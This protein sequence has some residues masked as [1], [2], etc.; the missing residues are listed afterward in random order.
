MVY[1][2]RESRDAAQHGGG[3]GGGGRRAS[4]LEVRKLDAMLGYCEL[5]HLPSPDA[6]RLLR[7]H[8]ARALR[9]LRQLPGSGRGPG[10]RT[11][12]CQKAMSCVYRTGPSA[13][14]PRISSMSC[15]AGRDPTA[16]AASATTAFR[17][18]GRARTW[19]R[20]NGARCSASWWRGGL[21][22]VDMEG[23]GSIR[24]TDASWP[25][26]RGET[27]VR[28]RPRCPSGQVRAHAKGPPGASAARSGDM[29]TKRSG[30]RCARP[31]AGTRAR[32]GRGRL[33]SSSTT[34]PLR[35]MVELRP[36]HAGR[37][38][39]GHGRGR[40]EVGALWRRL[41]WR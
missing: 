15:A 13:S 11:E 21:L 7:R 37:A 27:A 35:E 2:L 8:P 16:S 1:G 17:P 9:Q 20:T 29:G 12:A 14:G 3:L 19:V 26:L 28:M 18:T 36:D 31:P 10:M 38:G 34:P 30:R 41:F 4:V 33:T 23:Y 6:A 39:R 40:D 24:L 32:S 25:V 5:T 22:R